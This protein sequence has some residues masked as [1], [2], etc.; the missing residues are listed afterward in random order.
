MSLIALLISVWM[1]RLLLIVVSLML[2]VQI[3][4]ILLPRGH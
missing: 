3:L 1:L 4:G 2:V